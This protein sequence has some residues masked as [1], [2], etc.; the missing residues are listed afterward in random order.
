MK[1]KMTVNEWRK[2]YLARAE[3]WFMISR[4]LEILGLE[5]LARKSYKKMQYYYDI[6]SVT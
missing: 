5:R 4:A 2:L 3:R 1:M 6:V